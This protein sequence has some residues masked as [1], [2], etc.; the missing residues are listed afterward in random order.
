VRYTRQELKQ[1]KFAET[2]AGA[3]HWTVAHRETII[4]GVIALAVL[5]AVGVGIF[6]YRDHLQA[7]AAQKLGDAL[8]TFNAPVQPEAPSQGNQM[9]SFSSVADRAL[10]ARKQFYGISS[11]YGSTRAGQWAHYFAALCEVDLGNYAVAEGQLKDV[12]NSRDVEVSSLAKLALASVY[13]NEKKDSDAIAVYKDLI[14]H[15]TMSVPKS[16]AQLGLADL[17]QATQPAEANKLYEQI[18]K[19]DAKGPAAQ[20]AAQHQKTT[21]P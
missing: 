5:V 14:D 16:T 9:L 21:A 20:I 19:D 7:A 1:D 12:A 10:A 15:P 6:W 2:A 11:E 8:V 13:R 17:Y 4:S 3:V 18:A